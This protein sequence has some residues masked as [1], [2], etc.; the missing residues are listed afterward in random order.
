MAMTWR[1]NG[2]LKY[3]TW[4]IRGLVGKEP[5]LVE[6][7]KKIGIPMIALTETK[8]KGQGCE[9]IHDG[10]WLLYSGVPADVRAKAGVALLIHRNSI[11]EVKDWKYINERIMT[12]K[13][14]D[15][16]SR[17]NII[18][19]ICYGPNED[20]LA[21]TKDEFYEMLQKVLDEEDEDIL[22]LGD[23][24]GRVGNNTQG[25]EK[26]M[27]RYGEPETNSNGK[28]LLRFCLSNELVI[29]NT[30]F[31]HKDV[32]KYTRVEPARKEKSIIDYIIGR[33]SMINR[34][35]DTR[36]KRGPEVGSDHHL[37]VI[38]LAKKPW[39]KEKKFKKKKI[40]EKIKNF[41]LKE[42]SVQEK[43][44]K[45]VSKKIKELRAERC[46]NS[47][48]G[49]WANFKKVI[50]EAAE[51]VC[52]RTKCGLVKKETR[53]W[54]D[55]VKKEVCLKKV[56][57]KQYLQ[58]KDQ[59]SY[60][61]YKEQRRKV[62]EVIRDAKRETWEQFG[63][64]MEESTQTNQKLFYKI[65]KNM[66]KGK[67][68]PIKYINSKDGLLI[69]DQMKIMARWK[70]YFEELLTE[71]DNASQG[72]VEEVGNME[73]EEAVEENEE[74]EDDE[75]IDRDELT[76]ALS[77]MK[78]GK[79]AGHDGITPEMLRHMGEEGEEMLYGIMETAWNR[80]KIP[81]DWELSVIVPI[82][83]K[84]SNRECNN[85]RG[86]SL[87]SVPGKLYGRILETRLRRKV[88]HLLGEDQCGFRSNRSTQDLIFTLRQIMEKNIEYDKEVHLC[89][90]DL[91]KAFDR[92]PRSMI[93]EILAKR[94]VNKALIERIKS[95]YRNCR[96]YV[97]TSN[98][99]SEV[100]T[101]TAGVRQGDSLSPLLFIIFMD[102]IL[103]ACQN[104]TKN[105]QLGYRNL[106]PV[107]FSSLIYADDLVLIADSQ[108]KLQH[109]INVWV[110]ELEKKNMEVNLEKSKTMVVCR[111]EKRH[112]IRIKGKTLE[113]VGV[114]KYL[115]VLI[116]SDGRVKDELNSRCAASGKL[117]QAINK[118]FVS[119]REVSKQTKLRIFNS[120]Y[121]PTLTYGCESWALTKNS[122]NRIQ[123]A[124]MRYLRRV[125][126]KTRR[127]RVRNTTIRSN[128][129]CEAV[130]E[131]IMRTQLRWFGH[132]NRMEDT[133][134]P[135]R[136]YEARC[137]GKRPRGRR[138]T[139]WSDNVT[140][141]L[142]RTGITVN[143]AKTMARDRDG[144]KLFFAILYTAR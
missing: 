75:Y 107:T 101:T 60:T 34:V 89:F 38:N 16:E 76:V 84:G 24:N 94:N 53:W 73:N 54:S 14:Y 50:L 23:L 141:S 36:V 13:V 122:K 47:L 12:V 112:K 142:N 7:M 44:S 137:S 32:H 3:G 2:S 83:K 103:K 35:R 109:N 39:E 72:Y 125:E 48:E 86:I 67:E 55:E 58:I 31:P 51:E 119:K 128:L 105:F 27:G 106:Q 6:E 43:Y 17:R 30:M 41:K 130:V 9:T 25:F 68:C 114:Y 113:Q 33:R 15:K 120:I 64:F 131:R 79:S 136:A 19:I 4:N 138:R 96:N 85:H 117:F 5:E 11:N 57:W 144:W 91:C 18:M 49:M 63:K 129:G 42:A 69:T 61:L 116:S 118:K 95:F 77:R 21:E 92:V 20:E 90:I 10:F 99:S 97:R 104:K 45:I 143:K 70:E 115:G 52:G 133:R 66:R 1:G 74:E 29:F 26:A 111:T 110:E 100:F 123:A 139:T 134:H 87:L 8:K 88:D 93:W 108:A 28:R 65:L 98:L 82:F 56:L 78:L 80:R 62:K 46:S 22:I 59:Q 126:G 81:K 37:L 127:D 135:K 71:K 40:N 140:E 132:M 102:D 124:E 121:L